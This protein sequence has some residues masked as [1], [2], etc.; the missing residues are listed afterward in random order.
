LPVIPDP[1]RCARESA[2]VLRSGGRVVIMDKFVADGRR[3]PLAL[4]LANPLL[5]LL[6]TN[7]NGK[8]GPILEGTGMRIMHQESVG[9]EGFFKI[10]LLR[11]D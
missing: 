2:R 6:G 5:K 1:A 4:L 8:L 9:L 3:P 10:I 11:K 7:V